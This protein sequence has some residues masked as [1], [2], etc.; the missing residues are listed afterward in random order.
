ME[1]GNSIKYSV[2]D[3]VHGSVNKVSYSLVGSSVYNFIFK[4]VR[5]LVY[6]SVNNST[7]NTGWK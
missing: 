3:S 1:I 7:N 5:A 4:P 2:K 6:T